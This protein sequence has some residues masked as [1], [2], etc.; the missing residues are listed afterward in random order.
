MPSG[1]TGQVSRGVKT[2]R[3]VYVVKAY[4]WSIKSEDLKLTELLAIV[5]VLG[6]TLR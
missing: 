1:N 6:R 2:E 5:F 4:V 3:R